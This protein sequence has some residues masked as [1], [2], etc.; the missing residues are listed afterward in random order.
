MGAEGGLGRAHL[1]EDLA[2]ELHPVPVDAL[3]RHRA[4]VQAPRVVVALNEVVH[5]RLQAGPAVPTHLSRPLQTTQSSLTTLEVEQSGCR[6]SPEGLGE[7]AGLGE[8]EAIAFGRGEEVVRGLGLRVAEGLGDDLL[9]APGK[10]V[11]R[12][13]IMCAQSW[14]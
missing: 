11:R 3:H 2:D 6:G 13:R 4:A 14:R 10:C 7:L 5:E 1:D 9:R 8:G 12:A